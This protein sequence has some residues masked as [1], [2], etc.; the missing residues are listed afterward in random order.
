[1]VTAIILA[2]GCSTRLGTAKQLLTFRGHPLLR[3]ITENVLNTQVVEVIVVVGYQAEA[4]AQVVQDL[5]VTIALNPDY[6]AGQSTSLKVGL[7]AWYRLN[8][9]RPG[10]ATKRGIMFVLGDQPLV[11]TETMDNLVAQFQLQGGI[12]LPYFEG[13]RGNP[14]VLGEQYVPELLALTGDVGARDLFRHHSGQVVRVP[15]PDPGVCQD[16]DTWED[17]FRLCNLC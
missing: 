13:K 17:Y 16:I 7:Q 9:E 3:L 14:T 6:A 2:A 12:I 10:S 15:V 4:V 11:T 5:P 8:P 1:M